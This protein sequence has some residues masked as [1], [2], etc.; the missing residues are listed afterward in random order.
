MQKLTKEQ[1]LQLDIEDCVFL[2]KWRNKKDGTRYITT[3]ENCIVSGTF[4][5]YVSFRNL[6]NY[7]KDVIKDEYGITWDLEPCHNSYQKNESD[8][9]INYEENKTITLIKEEMNYD[10]W[11]DYC[12]ILGYDP[13]ETDEIKVEVKC[14]KDV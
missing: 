13:D 6:S 10:A 3:E 7:Y 5:G 8:Q 14:K 12:L 9:V 2:R 4:N 11:E 1:M